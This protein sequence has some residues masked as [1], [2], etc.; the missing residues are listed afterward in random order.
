MAAHFRQF[1]P[2]FFR[3]VQIQ[4]FGYFFSILAPE[5]QHGLS[6]K[7]T[8]SQTKTSRKDR[9]GLR[10]CLPPCVAKT[11]AVRPVFA[12]ARGSR[13]KNL[14]EGASEDNLKNEATPQNNKYRGPEKFRRAMDVTRS[15]TI[16]PPWKFTFVFPERERERTNTNC[17]NFEMQWWPCP[18]NSE[19]YRNRTGTGNLNRENRFSRNRNRNRNRRNR[20]SGTET[21]TGTVP[22]L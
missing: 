2:W 13:S 19:R 18:K 14:L 22:F 16:S 3:G 8:E 15:Y 20:C 11:C 21:R 4:C 12:R 17:R 1:F 6:A 10:R 9:L 5:A 7:P